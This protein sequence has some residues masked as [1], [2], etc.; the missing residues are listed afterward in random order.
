M[1]FSRTE[2]P[3]GDITSLA[4]LLKEVHS[5]FASSDFLGAEDFAHGG[6]LYDELP[7]RQR[8]RGRSDTPSV[9]SGIPGRSSSG[10]TKADERAAIYDDRHAH[11][12]AWFPRGNLRIA[13]RTGSHPAADR[14]RTASRKHHRTGATSND[15]W[16]CRSASCRLSG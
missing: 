16:S 10:L 2:L 5:E 8:A 7:G 3:N 15:T 1:E 9:P 11:G 6:G 4:C 12:N 13:P 14:S